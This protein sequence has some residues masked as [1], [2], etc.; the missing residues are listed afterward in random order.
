MTRG[1]LWVVLFAGLAAQGMSQAQAPQAAEHYR[2]G[3]QLMEERNY[4]RAATELAQAVAVDSTYGEAY[5]ALGQA[6]EVLD[7]YASAIAAFERAGRLDTMA[8][9]VALELG[10]LHYKGGLTQ[11]RERRY[12]E[13]VE[14]F[15]RALQYQP[16]AARTHY[17]MGL[18][19]SA[20]RQTD[21]A[22]Q[23]LRRAVDADT[24]FVRAYKALGDVQ[25][26]RGEYAPAARMYAKAIELD[27]TFAEAYGGLAQ[28]ELET[29]DAEATVSLMRRALRIEPRYADGY[30]LL[31]SALN[32]LGRQHEAVEPLGRAAEMAPRDA[33]VRYRLAEALYGKGDDRRALEEAQQAVALRRD[34]HVAE[35][36]LGDICQKLGQTSEARNW[37]A[38]GMQDSSLRDY[39][40]HKLQQLDEG[41]GRQ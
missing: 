7:E 12:Q 32:R 33:E 6:Y 5:F 20:L 38:K 16:K 17:A 14:S 29:N 15:A 9:R 3:Q 37:Y 8:D 4:R 39:A 19:Q 41:A 1:T 36:L 10:T 2:A 11:Y 26:S 28:V 31:G 35:V 30:L 34:F 27:S 24:G 13:A 25:R 23:S 18:C 21:Q 22:E 40:R